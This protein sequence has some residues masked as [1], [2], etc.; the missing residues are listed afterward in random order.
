MLK[1]QRLTKTSVEAVPS[2][3]GADVF[4]WD[5]E[6]PGFAI[7]VRGGRRVYVFAYGTGRRGATRRVTIGE[8]MTAWR[9]RVLTAHLARE[10]ALRLRGVV[11]EGRDP[12][13]ERGAAKAIPLFREFAET[14]LRDQSDAHKAPRSAV[15]DRSLLDRVLLPAFGSV[16]LDRVTAGA[17]VRLHG[18][19]KRTPTRANRALALLSHM[20][21]KA[22]KW[23]TLPPAH[24][25]PCRDV[26]R[27]KETKRERFLEVPELRRLGGVLQAE[28]KVRPYAV[29]ALRIIM[30]T[31][32]RVSEVLTLTHAQ[33]QGVVRQEAKG[34]R[35]NLYLAAPALAIAASLPKLLGNPYVIVG[36]RRG[37]HLTVSGLEQA[38]Q[39]I[40]ED[41]GL[42]D[43]RIHD[44]RHTF[45]SIGA[46]KGLTLP[47][48]GALL[49]HT[50][51]ATTQR[52]VHLVNAPVR[53]ANK[54]VV[55]VI[56]KALKSGE[57]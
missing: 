54:L 57:D 51:A 28:A 13:A 43:V 32:A 56:A 50:Q 34:G 16:R 9:D 11:A 15:E 46:G 26:T 35:R 27:Y 6:I 3:P 17:V 39:D 2:A 30:L 53:A 41:A 52:Y 23:G 47:M 36:H 4:V 49:G 10:E 55:D 12:A 20:F 5:T 14:Y 21:T 25:N 40:R 1:R 18:A 42:E 8:H 48:I 7:R 45:A 33:V 37:T 19:R 38:W 24:V 22:R 29:A 31:G 44:L